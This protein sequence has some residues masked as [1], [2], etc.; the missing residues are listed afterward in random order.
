MDLKTIAV[1]LMGGDNA[2]H[3]IVEGAFEASAEFGVEI[4]LVGVK[5]ALEGCMSR[6]RLHG[7]RSSVRVVPVEATQVVGA[8]ES[9]AEAWRGKKDSSIAVGIRMVKEGRA[10]AF[11]SA[12]NTGAI[13]ATSLFSLRTMVG[14][15]RPAIASL[16][17]T[18]D[19]SAALFLDIGANVDCR[20][21]FLFQFGQM[22][23]VFMSKIFRMKAPRVGLLSNGVEGEKGTKL[24]KET[25]K[26][27]KES[28]LNFVGNV[29]GFDVLSGVADVIV[30]DGFTGNVVLKLA[31]S[32][33]SSIFHS[34]KDA[35]DGNL[36]A[37][38]S[39]PLWGPPVMSVAKQWDYSNVGGALL[40]GVNGNIVMAHGR[41]DAADISSAIGLAQKMVGEGW[42][43]PQPESV[44][45]TVAS[46]V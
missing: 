2:P 31:E 38:A 27:L 15:D 25:H 22:G 5:D 21:R 36:L 17:S 35:L 4:A 43:R 32:L 46:N 34:L 44:Q 29:E 20:P 28:D 42:Y 8:A 13:A 30:T 26:L 7:G 40:L 45:Q 9:A 24:V 19:G 39:K 1:D 3:D 10:D 11:V 18:L 16:Y 12:G 37:R 33:A 23:S 6:L 14:V 41:S